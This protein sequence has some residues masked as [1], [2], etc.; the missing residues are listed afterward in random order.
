MIRRRFANDFEFDAGAGAAKPGVVE[1]AE[2]A[3]GAADAAEVLAPFLGPEAS[4]LTGVRS[5]SSI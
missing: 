1:G 4:K 2:L 5:S 3:E